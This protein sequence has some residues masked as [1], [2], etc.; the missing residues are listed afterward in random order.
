MAVFVY[1]ATFVSQWPGAGGRVSLEPLTCP[2]CRSPLSGQ[3]LGAI[4]KTQFGLMHSKCFAQV[5]ADVVAGRRG[6]PDYR[7]CMQEHPEHGQCLMIRGHDGPHRSLDSV[8]SEWED[9]S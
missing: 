4:G 8:D 7:Y 3:Q 6:L 1:N 2:H 5:V 9:K